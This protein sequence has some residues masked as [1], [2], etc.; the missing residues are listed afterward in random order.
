MDRYLRPDQSDVD[1][2]AP[3]AS[4]QW[5]YWIRTFNAFLKRLQSDD[6]GN[7]DLL[8]NFLAPSVYEH[9]SDC[10]TFENA[11]FLLES[12][13]KRY[14]RGTYFLLVNKTLGRT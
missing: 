7:L 9:I 11:I 1:L 3:N 8:I 13:Q 12:P 6:M 14:L 5:I 2:N 4:K 10:K